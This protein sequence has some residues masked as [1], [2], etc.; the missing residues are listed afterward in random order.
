MNRPLYRYAGV[1]AL[2]AAATAHAS[3]APGEAAPADDDGFVLVEAGN[4]TPPPVVVPTRILKQWKVPAN[5][6]LR[7]VLATWASSEGWELYWPRADE[8]TDLV[9][10]VDVSFGAASFEDA[11][12][13]FANGL[14]PDVNLAVTFNRANNPK[15]LHVSESTRRQTVISD[16]K[17]E[18]R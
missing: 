8:T 16:G 6:S 10:E 17:P 18:I 3:A 14:P 11:V 13:R 5:T 7:Q 1:L 15:L 12:T 2:V 9:S 4:Y